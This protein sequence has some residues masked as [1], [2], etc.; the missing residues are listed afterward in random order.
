MNHNNIAYIVVLITASS[1]DEA[2]KI[3]ASLVD[4]RVAA[5]ANII[6]SIQSIF[7]W[8]GDLCDE[9]EA[10]II[11]KTRLDLFEKLQAKVKELH[12]YEVPEIIALPIIKGNED[13]LKW[14]G[15]ETAEVN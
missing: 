11:V 14:V 8:K 5:C 12:S 2:R 6:S 13:Y 15:N 4:E 9:S 7:R 10:L 3:G 1:I